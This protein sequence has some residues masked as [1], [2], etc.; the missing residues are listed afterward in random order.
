MRWK[1]KDTESSLNKSKVNNMWKPPKI[2][3]KEESKLLNGID[4]HIRETWPH[5]EMYFT[6]DGWI[7]KLRYK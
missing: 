3:W 6:M 2:S 7:R 1:Q 5:L 4:N